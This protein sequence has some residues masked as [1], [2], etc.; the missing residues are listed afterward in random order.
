MSR[1]MWGPRGA[2]GSIP[3]LPLQGSPHVPHVPRATAQ[4]T[5]LSAGLGEALTAPQPHKLGRKRAGKHPG[6]KGSA[7]PGAFMHHG[8][9]ASPEARQEQGAQ[10]P[11]V[12]HGELEALQ[13]PWEDGAPGCPGCAG[14]RGA[15]R[16]AEQLGRRRRK[17][18]GGG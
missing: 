7:R 12:V 3:G 4:S 17:A 1:A 18:L 15:P 16:D 11:P 13:A 10:G 2:A 8:G 6:K 9:S 5:G 14:G